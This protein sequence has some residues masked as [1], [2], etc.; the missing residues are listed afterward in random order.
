[1]S[2]LLEL[3]DVSLEAGPKGLAVHGEVGFEAA[4]RLAHAGSDW[5]HGQPEG[6]RVIFDLSAV[7]GVSSAALSVLMEWTRTARLAGVTLETVRLP[8]A[9]VRL[10][11]LAGLDRFLPLDQVA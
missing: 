10:T 8:A 5:L 4:T 2:L 3:D 1:M 9:L 11:R 6:T 7:I